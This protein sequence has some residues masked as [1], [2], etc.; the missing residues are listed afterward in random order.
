MNYFYFI[1]QKWI[2]SDLDL[3]SKSD[4]TIDL[5]LFDFIL[6]LDNFKLPGFLN[7]VNNKHS[8]SKKIEMSIFYIYSLKSNDS[9]YQKLM[10]IKMKENPIVRL[11]IFDK[12]IFDRVKNFV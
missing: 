7:T 12:L 8:K 11:A 9:E 6:N 10:E 1:D 4:K 5:K 2:L 3:C